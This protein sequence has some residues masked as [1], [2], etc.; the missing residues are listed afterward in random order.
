[1]RTW[2]RYHHLFADLLALELRRTVPDDLPRLHA[3]ASQWFAENGYPV[4]AIRHA[5]AAEDWGSAARLLADNW[6]GLY[7]DGRLATAH[8]LLSRFPRESIQADPELLLLAMSSK[9]IAPTLQDAERY[10]ELAAGMAASVPKD[11]R[12]RFE[13]ALAICP[14]TL[15]RPPNDV[16]AVADEAQRLLA[17]TVAAESIEFGLGGDLHTSV[18]TEIGIA[19][20]WAGRLTDAER[21]LEAAL[22]EARRI[23]RPVLELEALAYRALLH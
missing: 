12:P 16:Q 6:R 13:I 8:E 23:G 15:A 19:E 14:M 7:L 5:Q 17:S 18:L 10:F 1:E 21:D 2:F 22:A 9:R 20:M 11:R 4:E 3:T